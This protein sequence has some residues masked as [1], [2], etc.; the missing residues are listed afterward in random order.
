EVLRRPV[1]REPLQRLAQAF[2]QAAGPVWLAPDQAVAQQHPLQQRGAAPP[3][4]RQHEDRLL[5]RV[6][7]CPRPALLNQ[8]ARFADVHPPPQ[9]P[10]R[11]P[12][13]WWPAPERGPRD[14]RIGP[15]PDARRK[16]RSRG[17]VEPSSPGLTSWAGTP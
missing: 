4:G 11:G 6:R 9:S 8:A 10:R 13:S 2:E 14:G 16:A 15:G 12:K 3:P 7:P 1:G 17:P 5:R